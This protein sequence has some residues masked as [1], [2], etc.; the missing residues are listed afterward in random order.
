MALTHP[1]LVILDIHMPGMNGLEL[2]ARLLDVDRRLP[3]VL[4]TAY[5][6]YADNYLAWPADAYVLKRGDLRELTDTVRR[7]LAT[8]P[9]PVEAAA[10]PVA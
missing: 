4:H 7:L 9:A 10:E 2:L 3:V 1:D 8:R 6:Y 5:D